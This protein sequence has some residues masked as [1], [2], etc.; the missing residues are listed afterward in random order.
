MSLKDK[1]EAIKAA[2]HNAMNFAEPEEVLKKAEHE[3]KQGIVD[4]FEAVHAKIKALEE[5]LLG[6][7]APVE[8]AQP[9]VAEN[10]GSGAAPVDSL[11]ATSDSAGVSIP[12]A[13]TA[14]DAV[15]VQSGVDVAAIDAAIAQQHAQAQATLESA[16]FATPPEPKVFDGIVPRTPEAPAA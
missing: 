4:E 6:T 3:F 14:P 11:G 12:A 8:N 16:M 2:I 15:A 7:S 5:K 1:F 9:A 13:G 10:T